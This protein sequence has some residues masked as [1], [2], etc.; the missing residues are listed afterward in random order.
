M[1]RSITSPPLEPPPTASRRRCPLVVPASLALVLMQAT[2]W[3]GPPRAADED[4]PPIWSNTPVRVDRSRDTRERIEATPSRREGP[5]LRVRGNARV[6]EGATLIVEGK[7]HRLFGLAP[8]PSDRVCQ[9][10]EG[11]RWACGQRAFAQL[12]ALI[13][14]Q[15]FGCR[16]VG[17]AE[18]PL[19]VVDCSGTERSI[20]AMLV[21][22][23]W[24]DLDPLGAAD[25][26]LAQALATA[27]AEHRGL[28]AP[29][30]PAP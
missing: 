17:A 6:G 15:S 21:A 29:T 22:R 26:T 1:N 10:A 7:R 23:G 8:P 20:S 13:A 2:A 27:K 9:D 4:V 30:A 18:D 11:R 3:A 12:S 5:A 19:P 28:W 16:F 14:G 25:P 24:S